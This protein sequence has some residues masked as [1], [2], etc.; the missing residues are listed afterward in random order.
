[1]VQF[2]NDIRD[3]TLKAGTH[4]SSMDTWSAE[5][6]RLKLPSTFK[7]ESKL[8]TF[9]TTVSR[10]VLA[11]MK[12]QQERS[13]SEKL[14]N[15]AGAA[16]QW[17][18]KTSRSRKEA[19]ADLP[20]IVH[21]TF[22]SREHQR[23]FSIGS[24]GVTAPDVRTIISQKDL[25]T[26]GIPSATLDKVYRL[27]E[28]YTV[29]FQNLLSELLE[30]AEDPVP[31]LSKVWTAF[32][33]QAE[34][35]FNVKFSSKLSEFLQ[36]MEGKHGEMFA[37]IRKCASDIK[38]SETMHEIMATA[39]EKAKEELGREV[40]A[41]S[42]LE[43]RLAEKTTEA[44]G[45]RSDLET[46]EC[47]VQQAEDEIAELALLPVK[48]SEFS[49][50]VGEL[51]RSTDTM[52][53]QLQRAQRE[54]MAYSQELEDTRKKY[55]HEVAKSTT[56]KKELSHLR[57]EHSEMKERWT[58]MKSDLEM[59]KAELELKAQEAEQAMNLRIQL[60]EEEAQKREY[61]E[62][63]QQA[64]KEAEET[65]RRVTKEVQI[66]RVLRMDLDEKLK[67][68]RTKSQT[69][70]VELDETVAELRKYSMGTEEQVKLAE[71]Q[72]EE[73]E[74]YIN[75]L[76]AQNDELESA[77]TKKKEE[78]LAQAMELSR[79]RWHCWRRWRACRRRQ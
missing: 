44:E 7:A 35:K 30:I 41:R 11:A 22:R 31:L 21:Q 63:L 38:H 70:Q 58:I 14:L 17:K 67:A 68:E 47:S 57:N 15:T 5:E 78:M 75:E 56:Q 20:P 12:K 28:L 62:R 29:G 42:E 77:F 1:M 25:E 45:L 46:T 37:S 34:H 50:R 66:L 65:K 40:A 79:R 13:A 19:K 72:K 69:L 55:G 4:D 32:L 59:T 2:T 36:H 74:R 52:Q 9:D 61:Y 54:N 23:M 26:F 3:S 64:L 10:E 49:R 43:Q 51:T 27:V 48:M 18:L 33:R 24:I 16:L 8:E 53:L 71:K 6:P 76:K 39:L 73:A 60:E